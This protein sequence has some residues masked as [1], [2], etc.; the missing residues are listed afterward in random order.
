MKD[1]YRDKETWGFKPYGFTN[2]WGLSEDLYLDSNERGFT[3][4]GKVTPS[5]CSVRELLANR[6]CAF[7]RLVVRSIS[8]R[9]IVDIDDINPDLDLEGLSKFEIAQIEAV[10]PDHGCFITTNDK[11]WGF[12]LGQFQINAS[13]HPGRMIKHCP[14][15][16]ETIY[17]QDIREGRTPHTGRTIRQ[18]V[19]LSTI[20]KWMQRFS[21]LTAPPKPHGELLLIDVIQRCIIRTSYQRRYFAL[22][23]VW[24]GSITLRCIK[25][26]LNQ[27]CKASSLDDYQSQIPQTIKDAMHLL[28][29]IGERYLWVDSL[30]IVQDD[31]DLKHDQISRMNIIFASAFAV[32]VAAHGDNA[33][34]GLPDVQP[35]SCR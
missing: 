19:D 23:Y 31:E 9:N 10:N 24:G 6:N 18:Q 33:D 3:G 27:L 25:C 12:K 16:I 28:S 8:T 4:K 30:C 20:E 21:D 11:G 17:L 32:I 29:H 15:F 34:A 2:F 7:C 5:L 14:R 1:A 22:S 26:N 13:L 35:Q